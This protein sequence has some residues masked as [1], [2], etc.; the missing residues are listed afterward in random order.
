MSPH[1]D[2]VLGKASS[3]RLHRLKLAEEHYKKNSGPYQ[4]FADTDLPPMCGQKQL[5]RA[6]SNTGS[7]SARSLVEH[8]VVTSPEDSNSQAEPLSR[9]CTT[10]LKQQSVSSPD[11]DKKP[12]LGFLKDKDRSSV[13]SMERLADSE[14]EQS[15]P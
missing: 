6:Y 1:Q 9:N 3:S 4:G 15:S 7:S 10:D 11:N 2:M 14:L 13:I 8:Q 12:R 5:E